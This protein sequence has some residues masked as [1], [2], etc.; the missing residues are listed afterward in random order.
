[1]RRR[2][3]GA[4]CSA[5]WFGARRRTATARTRC[6]GNRVTDLLRWGSA[7]FPEHRS[8]GALAKSGIDFVLTRRRFAVSCAAAAIGVAALTYCAAGYVHFKRVAGAEQVA[9]QRAD[10]ATAELQGASAGLRDELAAAQARIAP[11]S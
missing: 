1:M 4:C 3:L 2:L 7:V 10:R 6:R 11:P 5:A 8:F 9:A